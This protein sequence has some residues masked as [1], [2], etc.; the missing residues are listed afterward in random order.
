ME[1]LVSALVPAGV[2]VVI[3]VVILVAVRRPVPLHVLTDDIGVGRLLMTIAGT[4]YAVLVAFAVVIVWNAYDSTSDVVD[5]EAL[6]LNDVVRLSKAFPAATS[7][8]IWELAERYTADV[9]QQE[10]PAMALGKSSPT[11]R[12]LK[13]QIWSVVTSIKP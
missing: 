6:A 8:R 5:R 10:W 1:S 4:L 9:L 7:L 3:T 12:D 2:G 13:D 11:A